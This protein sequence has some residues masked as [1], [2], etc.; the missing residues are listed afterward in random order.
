MQT[1]EFK[2]LDET[3]YYKKLPNGLDVYILPKKGFSKTFVTFTTKYGSIDR[4]FVPIG[5][6]EAIT[7]PDGIAHF[8]EHKMFEKEDGDVFQKFSEVGAQANAFTSFTRTAYLFSSTDHIYKSTETLLNFVQEPYFTEETVNKEKGIIGQEITMYD[9][10]PDWRLY[11]GA[12]ENMYHNHPVKIDIAGTIDT[13]DGITAEHLYTCYN[14]FY[15]PSNMLLFVIGAVDPAEMMTFIENN[16]NEKTFPEATPL[17]RLF[18]EEPSNVAIKERVL[19]MDVQKPKVYVGLKAKEVNLSGEA[20]LKHELSVQIALECLFG[21]ASQFYTDMYDNGFIDESYGYDFSL[22]NGYGFALIGS[23]SEHPEQLVE[24]I[25][26]KLAQGENASVFT[27]EDVERIKRKKIGFFLRALNSIEFIA[28]QFTRY[29]FNEMNL[30]DVVP[31][32]ETITV[33][34]IAQAFQSI[35]GEEQQTVFQ[36]LPISERKA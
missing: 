1:I 12:I 23:D 26:A 11:F 20:M 8:L 14:T 35:Q 18:D 24:G 19:H 22:E 7:V 9:D 33:E 17:T 6:T 21:R 3:L 4:T 34:D 15:H 2:Q 29:K 30:F 10:S 27:A 31:V 28:N 16:Q 5:E 32:L 25:K 13:I 36:I